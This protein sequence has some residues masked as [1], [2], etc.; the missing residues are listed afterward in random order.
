MVLM[1]PLAYGFKQGD[2]LSSCLSRCIVAALRAPRW[3]TTRRLPPTAVASHFAVESYGSQTL[4]W[5]L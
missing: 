4:V 3:S 5:K 1:E 2:K